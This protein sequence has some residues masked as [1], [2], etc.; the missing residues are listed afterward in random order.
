MSEYTLEGNKIRLS[1]AQGI[2]YPVTDVVEAS[3]FEDAF[4]KF[5]EKWDLCYPCKVT[6]E[7]G[8]SMTNGAWFKILSLKR[9]LP[10]TPAEGVT[11][12]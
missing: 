2:H 5:Y 1:T 3:S 9:K 11:Q 7:D 4:E 10:T 6:D 12:D 8:D